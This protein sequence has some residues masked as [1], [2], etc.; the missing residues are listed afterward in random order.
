MIPPSIIFFLSSIFF[1]K[2]YSVCWLMRLNVYF[3]FSYCFNLKQQ[4]WSLYSGHSTVQVL[5]CLSNMTEL[6]MTEN[7]CKNIFWSHSVWLAQWVKS[8][9]VGQVISDKHQYYCSCMPRIWVCMCASVCKC[10]CVCNKVTQSDEIILSRNLL[11]ERQCNTHDTFW[12]HF[13]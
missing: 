7:G 9:T 4:L 1:F 6:Y 11:S 13:Y 10:H 3:S 8:V 5:I 12:N 2:M